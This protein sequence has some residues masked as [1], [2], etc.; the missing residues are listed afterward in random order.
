MLSMTIIMNACGKSKEAFM[1]NAEKSDTQRTSAQETVKTIT[2]TSEVIQMEEGFSA[3]HFHSR[4]E[5]H[6]PEHKRTCPAL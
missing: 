4:R 5:L 3:V 6:Y 2:L 1:E